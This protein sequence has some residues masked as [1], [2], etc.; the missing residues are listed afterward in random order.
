MHERDEENVTEVTPEGFQQTV[1]GNWIAYNL[2][3]RIY[4]AL[5]GTRFEIFQSV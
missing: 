3:T 2:N 4:G 5:Y 1:G